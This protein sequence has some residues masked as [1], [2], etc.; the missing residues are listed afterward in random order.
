M[1]R[2][3]AFSWHAFSVKTCCCVRVDNHHNHQMYLKGKR[4]SET[5]TR[6]TT[7]NRRHGGTIRISNGIFQCTMVSMQTPKRITVLFFKTATRSRQPVERRKK[8]SPNV[9]AH[10][11]S[12]NDHW[13][14][15][16]RRTVL[17]SLMPIPTIQNY[18]NR[19]QRKRNRTSR[20]RSRK[21]RYRIGPRY[22]HLLLHHHRPRNETKSWSGSDVNTQRKCPV[23][24]NECSVDVDRA[25]FRF[26]PTISVLRLTS[27]FTHRRPPFDTTD[28]TLVHIYQCV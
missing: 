2:R 11:L 14:Y 20:F 15:P 22:S 3:M 23:F 6:T 4:P 13:L 9:R 28:P 1:T 10:F 25:P 27:N 16:H 17:L 21:W 5:V 19:N 12:P 26:S 24:K 7:W 18:H 8:T